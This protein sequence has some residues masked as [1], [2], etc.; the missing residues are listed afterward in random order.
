MS[1]FNYLMYMITDKKNNVKKKQAKSLKN[2]EKF[3]MQKFYFTF[4]SSPTFPF[5]NGWI[6]INADCKSDAC[7]YFT[8]LYPNPKDKDIINCAFIYSEDE[9]KE[10]IM[11]ENGN[12]GAGCHKEYTVKPT[13]KR[14]LHFDRLIFEVTRRCNMSC[15]HCL[16]G[17]AENIDMSFE[18]VQTLLSRA[19][20]IHSITFSGG[21]PTLNLQFIRDVLTYVQKHRIPVDN[22]YIA[23]NGKHITEEFLI[24]LIEWYAYCLKWNDEQYSGV[25]ISKDEFHEAIPY[26]N[27][28]MLKSLS[29][30]DPNDKKSNFT[31]E[32]SLINHGRATELPATIYKFVPSKDLRLMTS[33]TFDEIEKIDDEIY[34]HETEIYVDCNGNICADCNLS[35]DMMPDKAIG[36]C[37]NIQ[38][39]IE[40]IE[41]KIEN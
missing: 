16:R 25:A 41:T 9:F 31:N 39:F 35:Y 34:L 4:G 26:Q 21:E 36:N 7:K 23:T 2:Q 33:N 29:F 38:S 20:H 3:I 22:F 10:T 11:Y 18:T 12:L 6:T 13:A 5:E 19:S 24:L 30:Y 40:F 14:L 32:N 8:E 28:L 27:E 15:K 37:R 1:F 17:D